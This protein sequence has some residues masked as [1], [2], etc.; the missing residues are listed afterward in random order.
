MPRG[1]CCE[2]RNRSARQEISRF[3]TEPNCFITLFR[4][5]HDKPCFFPRESRLHPDTLFLRSITTKSSLD[6]PSL[7]FPSNIPEK[8]YEFIVFSTRVTCS[9]NLRPLHLM[10]LLIFVKSKQFDIINKQS[11]LSPTGWICSITK[12][13]A[14]ISV[15]CTKC[16]Q[17]GV[18]TRTCPKWQ[19][20][21]LS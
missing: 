14:F 19:K 20:S 8:I 9:V 3:F 17:E 7:L 2:A 16:H 6:L 1:P 21:Q 10:A 5:Y 15:A 13:A 12:L 11:I 4:R 18:R